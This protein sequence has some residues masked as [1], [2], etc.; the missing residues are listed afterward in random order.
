MISNL[1]TASSE[2][3]PNNSTNSELT[4][5]KFCRL[6]QMSTHLSQELQAIWSQCMFPHSLDN[7]KRAIYCEFLGENFKTSPHRPLHDHPGRNRSVSGQDRQF[8][9]SLGTNQIA[10]FREFEP[11][12]RALRKKNRKETQL[13]QEPT[14]I[15]PRS[16]NLIDLFLT[17]KL[18]IFALFRVGHQWI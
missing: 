3:F 16:L 13:I 18:D 4:K 10:E 8:P 7:G 11:L 1:K 14:R 5:T 2:D 6:N 12:S 15:T 9:S 17:K